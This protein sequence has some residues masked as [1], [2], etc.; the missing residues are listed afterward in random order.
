M[1]PNRPCRPVIAL[2]IAALIT[3]AACGTSA[4][5]RPIAQRFDTA[6]LRT[7][8]EANARAYDN[9]ERLRRAHYTLRDSLRDSLLHSPRWYSKPIRLDYSCSPDYRPTDVSR[10]SSSD[11]CSR[12]REYFERELDSL[13][14]HRVRTR[15]VR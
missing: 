5:D 7:A 4:S 12:E 3:G 2:A 11:R 14:S 9:E 13:Y 8:A 15:A 1:I 10:S 6:A